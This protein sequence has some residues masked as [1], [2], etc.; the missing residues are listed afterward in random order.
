MYQEF[1]KAIIL[2]VDCVIFDF[3]A[4]FKKSAME[5]LKR[6]IEELKISYTLSE[7]FNINKEDV[8]PIFEHLMNIGYADLPLLEGAD[9]AFNKLKEEGYK[10]HIVTGIPESCKELRL[11]NFYKYG[12][13][14]DT[15]DCV[16]GGKSQ[17]DLIVREY[18]PV[19]IADDRIQHLE[20]SSFVP[21]KIWINNGDNQGDYLKNEK[22][23]TYETTSLLDWVENSDLILKRDSLSFKENRRNRP[24]F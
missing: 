1:N 3:Y 14:P 8:S 9:I 10:I 2:D 12:L 11:N 4:G 5:V 21:Q 24:R 18:N 16:G 22:N 6:D 23:V 19:A 7:R 15:I 20:Q 13:Y 17:K